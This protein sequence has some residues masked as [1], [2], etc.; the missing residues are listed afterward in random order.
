MEMVSEAGAFSASFTSNVISVSSGVRT[1]VTN[2][3]SI[4]IGDCRFTKDIRAT[5]PGRGELVGRMVCIIYI[6]YKS[7]DIALKDF[8]TIGMRRY[9]GF[10]VWIEDCY[11]FVR[12]TGKE[13]K[14]KRRK[15][16]IIIRFIRDCSNQLQTHLPIVKPPNE[17]CCYLTYR[18]IYLSYIGQPH[19]CFDLGSQRDVNDLSFVGVF[20]EDLVAEP[21]VP[22]LCS[23]F[24]SLR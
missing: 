23:G 18:A 7:D 2:T 9:L 19:K 4:S 17:L 16:H 12:I 1:D 24:R 22:S 21:Y 15:N 3:C 6:P 8:I 13:K 20:F 11:P 10:G 14:C 5:L